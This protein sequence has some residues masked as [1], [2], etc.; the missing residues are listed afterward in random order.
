[1]SRKRRIGVL[2]NAH[3]EVPHRPVQLKCANHDRRV[4]VDVLGLGE[5]GVTDEL[6]AVTNHSRSVRRVRL[7]PRTTA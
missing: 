1:M 3:D 2:V 4:P 6:E 5:R 7:F